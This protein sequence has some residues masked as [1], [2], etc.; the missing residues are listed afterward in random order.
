[1]H[2]ATSAF[3]LR[4]K[5]FFVTGGTRGIGRG[6][7]LHF[8]RAGAAVIAGY[9][10]NTTAARELADE[11]AA[12]GLEVELCRADLT[13]AKGLQQALDQL[14]ERSLSGLV[15]SSATGVHKPLD[16][17]TTRH[18]DWT[19]A[20]N[21][22]SF[23]ELVVRLRDR[24]E[25]GAAIVALSSDGATRALPGYSLIGS[26]KGALEALCRHLAV[27]LAGA[28]VRVNILA[29]GAVVTEAW[30]AFPDRDERLATTKS[31]TPSGELT[32]PLQVAHAAHF[33][34][35][36]ASRQITGQTLVVDGGHRVVF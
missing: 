24:L 3:S 12:E 25:H 33:L 5:R 7:T 31:R 18:F 9:V 30:D 28:G 14:G 16:Q 21:V 11:A 2:D 10:R 32:T 15:F 34:C 22:R 17:L 1:M 29:P 19:F 35:A 23:F 27:E 26:S 6:I 13:H 20:L 8:A 36:D 4:G